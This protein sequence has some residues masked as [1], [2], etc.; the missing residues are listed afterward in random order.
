MYRHHRSFYLATLVY[1]II[2]YIL[3]AAF[4]NND[5][6]MA[7]MGN[8]L[9]TIP[10]AAASVILWFVSRKTS[11]SI[12][13]FWL[14]L[15][16]SS[17]A[18]M[19]AMFFWIW[20]AVSPTYELATPAPP[21]YL[22]FAEGIL[23]CAA[24][25]F[26]NYRQ[27]KGLGAVRLLLDA[28]IFMMTMIALS[29]LVLIQPLYAQAAATGNLIFMIINVSYPIQ[30]LSFLFLLMLLML[31][32]H[33]TLT[34][35]TQYMLFASILLFVVGDSIYLYLVSNDAYEV[36]S[37][38]DP[39]WSMS[40]MMMALAGIQSLDPAQPKNIVRQKKC[41]HG[42]N[43]TRRLL[44]YVSLVTLMIVMLLQL[45]YF[46]VIVMC[47]M[48]GILL[49]TVRQ[50]LTLTENEELLNRLGKYLKVSD[51]AANHDELTGLPNRR[52]FN[53]QLQQA[54]EQAE[55][56]EHT[57]FAI[58]FMDFN[59]FKYVNDTLGHAIGDQML[60]EAARRFTRKLPDDCL[61]ARLGGDEFVILVPFRQTIHRV[62]QAIDDSLKKPMQI[63]EHSLHV[64]TSIGVSLYPDNGLSIN[65]LLK[66]ADAAM[67]QS[68]KNNDHKAVFFD[69]SIGTT[70]EHRMEIENDLKDILK[71][72]ELSLHYQLQVQ[73]G[74]N[75]VEGVEALLRWN[76]P[77]KG[78]ISPADFI[79]IAEETGDI[80]SI[81]EWVLRQACMQQRDWEHAG[82]GSLRMSVN[83]SA[84]QLQH[85]E[86]VERIAHIIHSTGIDPGKLVLEITET[87]AVNDIPK[88]VSK[89]DRL[90]KIG[91]QIAI[92]DFGSGYSSL[93][94]LK[95]FKPSL[96]KIDRSFI[97]SVR[98]QDEDA[99][100]MVCAIINLAHG[101]NI[102]VLAEGVETAQQFKFLEDA[103]CNE[104]QGYLIARPLPGKEVTE[105]LH[106]MRKQF[107][108]PPE[109][110]SS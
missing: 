88:V 53:M 30:D 85:D 86:I 107:K 71:R 76:H 87:F 16:F 25:L 108:L 69:S 55:T 32:E 39:L 79:P 8:L 109:S 13:T 70:L 65:E 75:K 29:W 94:Y 110:K 31:S 37:F 46:N 35:K 4:R 93:K 47:C 40:L 44:P 3:L 11:S 21:D 54:I 38:I 96:L 52:M 27:L 50:V 36:G 100:N 20:A 97:S 56:K 61:L 66:N 62:V 48:I 90:R 58:V 19:L 83:I 49:V 64:S 82:Y 9:N 99:D 91:I 14:L 67:Y 12:R 23:I 42:G 104:A 10:A 81:G 80:Q 102:E 101:L 28:S 41:E 78:F 2:Y 105:R 77:V 34:E 26:L 6:V 73:M 7:W 106:I 57:K 103:G 98:Q 74:T 72:N 43:W 95:N 22:W 17:L 60:Q 92:D 15:M 51:Y 33:R 63:E 84:Y 18:Y 68:K 24:L 59:R 45:P 1:L 89:L 5:S